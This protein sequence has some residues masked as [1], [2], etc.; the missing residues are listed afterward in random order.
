[1]A[2]TNKTH[3]IRCQFCDDSH[4]VEENDQCPSPESIR[5]ACLRIQ[6]TW[7]ERERSKRR[8]C[9][10]D[11]HPELIQSLLGQSLCGASPRVAISFI[12]LL[13]ETFSP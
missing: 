9:A 11:S 8:E 1:M 7:D 13:A 12:V 2:A 4:Y 6:S 3:R 5:T 10:P